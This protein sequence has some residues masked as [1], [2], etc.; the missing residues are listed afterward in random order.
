[1]KAPSKCFIVDSEKSLTLFHLS[2]CCMDYDSIPQ[3]L[4]EFV[5]VNIGFKAALCK[6]S[7]ELHLT[8]NLCFMRKRITKHHAFTNAVVKHYEYFKLQYELS[9]NAPWVQSSQKCFP[10]PW[11]IKS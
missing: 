4:L 3:L 5:H 8:S 6:K 11:F 10:S 9:P 2:R 7:L 1:M